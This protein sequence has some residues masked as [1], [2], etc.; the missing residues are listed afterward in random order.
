MAD[1]VAVGEVQDD[2][3]VLAGQDAL[4]AL[5]G[6]G[7]LAHLRLEVIGRDLGGRDQRAVLARIFLFHAAVEEERDVR[8]LLGLGD[9]QLSHAQVG[10]I[11][12]EGVLEALRL[13]RDLYARDGQRR[14]A[15]CRRR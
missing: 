5:L 10:D 3:V 15:S 7:G 9:A 11:L 12:A 8:V 4:D 6:D 1:H 13:E 2:H 14:T